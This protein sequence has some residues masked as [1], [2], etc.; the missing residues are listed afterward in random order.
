MELKNYKSSIKKFPRFL[1]QAI[2]LQN[3]IFNEIHRKKRSDA[4]PSL[5]KSY[6][7]HA[8]LDSSD[9]YLFDEETMKRMSQER[10]SSYD[11]SRSKTFY[12]P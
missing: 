6:K 7:S 4:C 10:C 12:H 5:V 3:T 8:I 11:K 1:Q 2:R 9:D